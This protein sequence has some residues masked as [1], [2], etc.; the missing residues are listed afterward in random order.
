[1]LK[2]K[3]GISMIALVISIIVILIIAGIGVTIGSQTINDA[4]KQTIKTNMLLIEAKAKLCEES[5]TFKTSNKNNTTEIE[6]IKTQ[7]Y[8]GTKLSDV[9]E[10]KVTEQINLL[11]NNNIL[12]NPEGDAQEFAKY[13]YLNQDNLNSFG[14]N[15]VKE[16]EGAYYFVKYDEEKTEVVFTQGYKDLNGNVYYTLSQLE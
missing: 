10:Q 3:K 1:M 9:T 11:V 6:Q 12:P 2:N 7:E 8:I 4:H 5:V 15:E 16:S 13:Y 14:L